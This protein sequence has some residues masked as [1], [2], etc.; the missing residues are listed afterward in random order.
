MVGLG[1]VLFGYDIGMWSWNL[2][3]MCNIFEGDVCVKIL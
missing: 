2:G 3:I 1:G